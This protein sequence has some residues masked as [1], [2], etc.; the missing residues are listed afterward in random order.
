MEFKR[1]SENA[2]DVLLDFHLLLLFKI[3][4][5]VFPRSKMVSG[6]REMGIRD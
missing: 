6:T 5:N 1:D 3:F 2:N 4:S